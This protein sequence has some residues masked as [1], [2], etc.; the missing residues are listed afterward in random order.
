MS[1]KNTREIELAFSKNRDPDWEADVEI[2]RRRKF[3]VV[4]GICLGDEFTEIDS[5]E[6]KSCDELNEMYYRFDYNLWKLMRSYM[7]EYTDYVPIETIHIT[8][9]AILCC[10]EIVLK[11]GEKISIDNICVDTSSNHKVYKLY[12]NSTY[13]D[14][15]YYEST[16]A[17]VYELAS[18]DVCEAIQIMKDIMDKQRVKA[19][20]EW[21][22][23]NFVS[24][25]F[26]TP[27]IPCVKNKYSIHDLVMATSKYSCN[28]YREIN[29]KVP[30][31]IDMFVPHPGRPTE[32]CFEL[33]YTDEVEQFIKEQEV[34]KCEETK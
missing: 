6:C 1:R 13:T 10:N 18:K 23:R 9:P 12:S 2:Y 31:A 34:K 16:K 8:S 33:D 24:R 32:H 3:K 30:N 5:L 29:K 26:H 22:N 11:N 27:Q 20:K 28:I 21:N 4:R 19:Q 15:V 17:L 25:L 7:H 14:D